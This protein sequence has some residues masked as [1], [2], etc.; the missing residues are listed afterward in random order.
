MTS[1][2]FIFKKI[3][4]FLFTPLGIL[5]CCCL[6]AFLLKRRWPGAAGLLL[7]S[8]LFLLFA[9]AVPIVGKLVIHPLEARY[10]QYADAGQLTQAGVKNIVVL[11]AGARRGEYSVI[12]Q[13]NGEGLTR[14]LEG[15][16]LYKAIPQAKLWLAGGGFA[17]Q[18]GES[19]AMLDFAL[20]LGVPGHDIILEKDS[21]DTRSQAISLTRMLAGR[22][23]AL[24]TS[25]WHMPRSMLLFN[26]LGVN[27][28]PAPTDF[29]SRDLAFG[30]DVLL[31]R[32]GGLRL[33]ELAF[34][35]YLGYI[36][37]SIFKVKAS[38]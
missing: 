8:G 17:Q 9:L 36:H 4:S 15:A 35:E 38:E 11:G 26:Q 6:L 10:Y 25:A 28:L 14:V 2:S 5:L 13:M 23:F 27:P 3:I 37:T 7:F 24:V 34:K 31:P 33:S 18:K 16:R 22:P 12:D 20:A 29:R 21:W 30:Y 32:A 1:L 19:A